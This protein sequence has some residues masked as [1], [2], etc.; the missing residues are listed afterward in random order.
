MMTVVDEQKGKPLDD[1]ASLE[2]TSSLAPLW[3]AVY[4]LSCRE[5]MCHFYSLFPVLLIMAQ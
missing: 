3:R 5:S 4:E 1:S 2:R